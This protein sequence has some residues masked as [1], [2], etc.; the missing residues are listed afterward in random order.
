[1]AR[2]LTI[3]E[4][5]ILVDR[6]YNEI[7]TESISVLESEMQNNPHYL[8]ILACRKAISD[9]Q[10][11]IEDIEEKIKKLHKA[12]NEDLNNDNFKYSNEYDYHYNGNFKWQD[13]GLKDKIRTEVVL[14]NLGDA[15]DFEKL[16]ASLK[17]KF[18]VAE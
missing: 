17:D 8:D 5:D 1:M 15:V 4:R 13:K 14:A 2:K 12:L 9:K 11:E 18:G 7:R 3:N 6:A 16:I 10:S